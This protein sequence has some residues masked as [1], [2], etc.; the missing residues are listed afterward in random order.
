MTMLLGEDMATL[1]KIGFAV[2]ALTLMTCGLI[3][4]AVLLS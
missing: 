3:G 4:I 1:R 2:S